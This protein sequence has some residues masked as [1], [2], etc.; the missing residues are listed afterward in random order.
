MKAWRPSADPG[1]ERA[2][3]LAVALLRAITRPEVRDRGLAG[4]LDALCEAVG[5]SG[6]VVRMD[7][8]VR[9]LQWEEGE[10]HDLD[11]PVPPTGRE[12]EVVLSHD[13]GT[14]GTLRVLGL[15]Q[16]AVIHQ[17]LSYIGA[18]L[19]WLVANHVD[20][21]VDE[22]YEIK[23]EVDRLR[24]INRALPDGAVLV[25]AEGRVVAWNRAMELLS[26]ISADAA[27]LQP[28]SGLLDLRDDA[29]TALRR[30]TVGYETARQGI[31]VDFWEVVRLHPRGGGPPSWVEIAFGPTGDE[32]QGHGVVMVLR[33]VTAR[34]DMERSRNAFLATASHELR[35]PLTP[36]H[37]VLELL[38]RVGELPASSVERMREAAAR[39]IDRLQR[40]TDDI[41][42]MVDLDRHLATGDTETF[43]PRAT[44]VTVLHAR[45]HDDARRVEIVSPRP[46]RLRSSPALVGRILDI[47]LDNALRHTRGPITL[48]IEE[49]DGAALLTVDDAGNGIPEEA[50]E[51]LLSPVGTD[52][53]EGTGSI[54]LG[55]RIGRT[56][57][58]RL[59][60]DLTL[61]D[62]PTG[63]VRAR[64][65][66]PLE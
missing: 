44:A 48:T 1:D 29:G 47:L 19:G 13:G 40:L 35:S 27:L 21:P 12:A 57:A 52:A 33:D 49:R 59:G 22:I 30:S 51:R 34:L 10:L 28:W 43:D 25:S 5:G 54:G 4:A 36:L 58:D 23:L 15:R 16:V 14:I 45:G 20:R 50:R 18:D 9:I 65:R 31:P 2:E 8:P 32:T 26:G 24:Q 56:L 66:L 7:H 46:V 6:C 60:G 38:D 63:G 61:G 17:A 42:T 53:T 37:A 64:V 11:V 62:S 39:Q 3:D 41:V 55:L